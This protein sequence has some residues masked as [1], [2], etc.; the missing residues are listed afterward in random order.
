MQQKE[1]IQQI[2]IEEAII[3]M[4][5]DGIV[6]V[7]F[8]PHTQITVEL[9]EKLKSAYWKITDVNRP[10][11]FEGGEFVGITKEAR[12]NAINMEETTPVYGSVIIVKN[13]GQRIIADYYYRFNK[14]KRPIKIVKTKE[15]ALAWIHEN[16][17]VPKVNTPDSH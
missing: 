15:D 3:R 1:F 16:F 7:Y 2:E 10:F 8:K 11:I 14:P 17:T 13:L 4:R 5:A 6:H 9:Q 12:L